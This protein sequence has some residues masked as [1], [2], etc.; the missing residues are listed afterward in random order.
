MSAPGVRR[1][2][3]R[4]SL[5][6]TALLLFWYG[7]QIVMLAVGFLVAQVDHVSAPALVALLVGYCLLG[8]EVD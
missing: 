6:L 4:H 1:R 5:R 3:V 8:N 2:I 7:V